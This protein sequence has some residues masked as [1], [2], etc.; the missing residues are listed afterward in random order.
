MTQ[1]NLLLDRSDQTIQGAFD[2][3]LAIGAEAENRRSPSDLLQQLLW[4]AN[5]CGC[6]GWNEA[7]RYILFMRKGLEIGEP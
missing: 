1:A 5:L 7:K 4:T 3:S 2:A 6:M